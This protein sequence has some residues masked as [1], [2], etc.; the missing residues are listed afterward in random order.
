MSESFQ[1]LYD[2]NNFVDQSLEYIK[3]ERNEEDKITKNIIGNN[4]NKVS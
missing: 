2:I 1:N 3:L 4:T